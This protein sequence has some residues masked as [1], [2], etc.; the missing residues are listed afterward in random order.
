MERYFSVVSVKKQPRTGRIFRG[1]FGS[2]SA[3]VCLELLGGQTKSLSLFRGNAGGKNGVL[4][5]AS[6]CHVSGSI[7]LH[8]PWHDGGLQSSAAEN[9]DASGE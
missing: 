7:P 1:V 9:A 4:L 6:L 5:V 3:A 2:G 8:F